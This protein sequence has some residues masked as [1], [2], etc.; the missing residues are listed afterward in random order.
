[1]LLIDVSHQRGAWWQDLVDKDEDGL[2]CGELDAL[3]D[4]EDELADGKVGWDEVLLLVDGGDLGLLDLLADD[5]SVMLM[6]DLLI[7]SDVD[8]LLECGRCTLRGYA[9]PLPCASQNRARP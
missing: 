1:M 5:L 2:L 6:Y 7:A 4:D 3:A 9:R 8:D